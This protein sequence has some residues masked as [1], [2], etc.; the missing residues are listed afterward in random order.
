MREM[1]KFGGFEFMPPPSEDYYKRLPSRLGNSLTSEQIK[2]CQELGLLVDK[3]DK[4][5]LLQI[6]TQ[7][8]GDRPTIFIE[9]IQRVGCLKHDQD[10]DENAVDEQEGG[11]GGFG[12]GNFAELFKRIEEY[13]QQLDI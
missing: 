3:D 4:G 2:Q 1:Q 10:E 9:I 11:C 13:E 8:L 5:V 12:K 7:P 6:F